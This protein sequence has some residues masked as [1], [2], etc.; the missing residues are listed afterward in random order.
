ASPEIPEEELRRHN[1]RVQEGAR[2][3][4]SFE[5]TFIRE[6]EA[7]TLAGEL[8]LPADRVWHVLKDARGNGREIA[9]FLRE[10]TPAHGE[11]PLRLLESL[12]AK[13]WTDTFRPTLEDHLTGA[14]P[15]RDLYDEDTFVKY[16]LCPRVLFEMIVPYKAAFQAAI[17]AEA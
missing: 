7:G 14:L 15:F 16:I 10:Q 13:D 8:G 2:I 6:P 11:L 4:T 1:A 9:A 5:A 12:N 3:R 17:P